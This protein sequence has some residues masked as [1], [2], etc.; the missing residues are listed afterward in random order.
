MFMKHITFANET[1]QQRGTIEVTI[2]PTVPSARGV[3]SR[4]CRS[5]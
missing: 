1:E 2:K 4:L 3:V 5:V